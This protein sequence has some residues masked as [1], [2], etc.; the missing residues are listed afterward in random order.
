MVKCWNCGKETDG[1][2]ICNDCINEIWKHKIKEL[3]ED[4]I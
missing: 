3:L 1:G 2:Q 4:D